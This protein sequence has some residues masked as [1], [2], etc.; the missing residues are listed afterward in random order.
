MKKLKFLLLALLVCLALT[1]C[2]E[3]K[4]VMEEI[5]SASFVKV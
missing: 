3:G 2:G 4:D 5:S 1:A